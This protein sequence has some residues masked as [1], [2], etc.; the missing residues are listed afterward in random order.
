M[1]NSE[2][3]HSALNSYISMLR[4]INVSGQKKV[5]MKELEKLYETLGLKNVQTY[6]QSGNVVFQTP[7]ADALSLAGKIERKIEQSFGFNVPIFIR[8][9]GEF[10][11][12]IKNN[13]FPGRDESKLHVTFLYSKPASLR[14][15]EIVRA[16]DNAEEFSSSGR[17]IYLFLPNGYGRTKLSN[18]FFERKSKV[19]ATTRNW[20]TLNT[21]FS[22][23]NG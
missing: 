7:E 22:M 10:Q 1:S 20:R 16:K 18:S 9:K 14:M 13:P 12:L 6:I 19:L 17:E 2:T 23:S 21:L 4:G 8:T 11:K 3:G 15:D 5:N